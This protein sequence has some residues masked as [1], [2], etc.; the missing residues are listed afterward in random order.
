M[1]LP[2][3]QA[4]LESN[5]GGGKTITCFIRFQALCYPEYE[6]LANQMLV[7]VE[8]HKPRTLLLNFAGVEYL[9]AGALGQ[10]VLLHDRLRTRGARL[11]LSHLSATLLQLLEITR[12]N[13]ILEVRK[14][15]NNAPTLP[16]TPEV[17]VSA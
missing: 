16:R 10:L 12:L 8:K 17:L 6:N 9:T 7:L 11:L 1:S 4:Y 15:E 5:E 2:I 13:T 3:C 14:T